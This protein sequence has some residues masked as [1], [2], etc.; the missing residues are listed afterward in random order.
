[1]PSDD[2]HEARDEF[3]ALL[4]RRTTEEDW[5]TF[6]AANPSVLS[7]SLP[8]RMDPRDIVPLGRPGKT[9]P[10][11]VFFPHGG[12]SA[13]YYGVIELKRPSTA[14]LTRT[15]KNVAVLSRDAATAVAQAQEYSSR[16]EDFAPV[17][18]PE[19]PVFL[20]NARHNFVVLGL[21][22]GIA[23][24]FTADLAASV[25]QLALPQGLQIIPF[26]TL[27]ERFE[28][29]LPP[30]FHVL[31]PDL[32]SVAVA[33]LRPN[34]RRIHGLWQKVHEA[35]LAYGEEVKAREATGERSAHGY[36][37]EWLIAWL[38]PDEFRNVDQLKADLATGMTQYSDDALDQLA[39]ALADALPRA[40]DYGA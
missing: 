30:R 40:R 3:R 36:R 18:L 25:H 1:M 16:I 14:I 31:V 9:E 38:L 12:C 28:S 34:V 19:R 13:S 33:A 26:D 37:P 29:G 22:E 4:A 27:L 23:E 11:F 32:A 5:Q 21:R 17:E 24:Q 8:L 15:R 20:G 2:L 39:H 35:A 6:F 10:D 7:R